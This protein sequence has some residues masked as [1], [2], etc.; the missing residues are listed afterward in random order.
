MNPVRLAVFFAAVAITGLDAVAVPKPIVIG[1][2]KGPSGIG[3]VKLFEAPPRPADGSIVRP[4][5]VASADLMTAKLISGEYDAGVLPLNVAAKLYASGI[6]IKL[7][8]VVGDGMVSFLSSDSAL[9]SLADLKGKRIYVAGQG[10]TPDYLL[11]KLLKGS[12]IDPGKDLSLDYSLPYPEAAVALASGKIS[13][14]IL[15]EP[16]VTMAKLQ[17]PKLRSDIN[18]GALWTEQ[19]GQASY[20]MTAFVVSSSLAPDAV[21]TILDAYAA[22]IAWVVAQP[23][24]AGLLV[25][26]EELGLKAGIAAKAIPLSAYVFT[27]ARSARPAVEA[28]LRVF[29]ELAPASVGGRLPDDGFY[30][31]FK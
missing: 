7:A 12:G 4:I 28:L 25:E 15:P 20:P 24:E 16:F 6:A 30:A 10:A 26:K 14:A 3:M 2:L 19:T 23:D 1:A 18:L 22:S 31:S 17:N 11:R 29:L 9:S 21:K 5:A 27:D 8:A 13:Y